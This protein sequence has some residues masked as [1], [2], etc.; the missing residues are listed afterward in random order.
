MATE[1]V[2]EV[3]V[4]GPVRLRGKWVFVCPSCDDHVTAL[5]P[6][7]VA[8]CT[9]DWLDGRQLGYDGV[10]WVCWDPDAFEGLDFADKNKRFLLLLQRHSERAWRSRSPRGPTAVRE[11]KDI[12][13][14]RRV[15][16]WIPW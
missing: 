8:V 4:L 2:Q 10:N 14:A 11:G 16:D 3:H 12:R 5:D 9:S 13:L 7:Q 6:G 1:Q 15:Q